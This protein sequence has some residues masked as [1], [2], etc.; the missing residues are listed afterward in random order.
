MICASQA[1]PSDCNGIAGQLFASRLLPC[2]GSTFL[3]WSRVSCGIS[4]IS[5]RPAFRVRW[6]CQVCATYRL[7]EQRSLPE[8]SQ[9]HPG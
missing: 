2:G 4:A 5:G 3:I 1:N 9:Q 8:L 7:L 6:R